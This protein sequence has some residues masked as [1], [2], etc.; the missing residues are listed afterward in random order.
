MILS[1]FSHLL[2]K[3]VLLVRFLIYVRVVSSFLIK[4]TWP[5]SGVL[6]FTV[7][8]LGENDSAICMTPAITLTWYKYLFINALWGALWLVNNILQRGQTNRHIHFP[9]QSLWTLEKIRRTMRTHAISRRQQK[10]GTEKKLQHN[11]DVSLDVMAN[12]L[13]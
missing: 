7:S 2:T 9:Q 8:A 11:S 13:I 6:F 10:E 4:N 12:L 1:C 5:L 3:G